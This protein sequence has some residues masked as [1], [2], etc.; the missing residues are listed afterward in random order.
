MTSLAENQIVVFDGVESPPPPEAVALRAGPL[1]LSFVA[2]DLR[3]VALGAR[4]IARRLTVVVR[5]RYWGTLPNQ[6]SNL[7][8]EQGDDWFHITYDAESRRD[9]IDFAWQATLSGD[10]QGTITFAFQGQAR[11]TFPSNRLGLVLLHPGAECAGA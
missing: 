6:L 5:D 9:E 8:L 10:A 4:E 2:G 1:S 3:W 11:S 7:Q